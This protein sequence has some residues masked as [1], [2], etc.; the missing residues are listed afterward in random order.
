[1]KTLLKIILILS[2]TAALIYIINQ[3]A[4]LY[5]KKK[6][7]NNF[8]LDFINNVYGE[9]NFNDYSQ[10]ISQ[11]N[12][13]L[14][15]SPFIEFKEDFRNHK[16]VTVN[17]NGIRCN[18]NF[19][20]SCDSPQGGKNEIWI[21]GGSTIFGYGVKNDETLPAYLDEM[22]QDKK[23]I[24]IG[25]GYWYSTQERIAYLNMLTSLE[26]PY[27][28]IFIDGLNE[29]VNF[30]DESLISDRIDYLYNTSSNE[31][32][33]SKI[34]SRF[35]SLHILR[36]YKYFFSQNENVNFE[37]LYSKNEIEKKVLRFIKNH[38]INYAVSIMNNTDFLHVLQPL[39][40][41]EDSY[42]LSNFP[43]DFE[44]ISNIYKKN[45]SLFY[46]EISNKENS[47][48]NYKSNFLNLS[49]FY[50]D[51]IMYVDKVHYSPIFNEAIATEIYKRI[52]Q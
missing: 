13:P 4:K 11:L 7:V 32:L 17:K 45:L 6:I 35:N 18:K 44:K 30:E 5:L 9:D 23:V 40:I 2:I 14:I 8:N 15:Y 25:S 29:I 49:K 24:N 47:H 28:S 22:F 52:V 20:K 21:F 43:K 38:N 37:K 27:M 34:I 3:S 51:Q 39:P 12:K 48:L 1:M 26:A 31:L 50:I 33:K 41:Y 36:L 19:I 46:E 10:V 42:E 16:F